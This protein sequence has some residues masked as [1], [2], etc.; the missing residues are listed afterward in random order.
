MWVLRILNAE[1]CIFS[2]RR[3]IT[4]CANV[5]SVIFSGVGYQDGWPVM[6]PHMMC[7]VIQD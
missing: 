2:Q 1:K 3:E 5:G 4:A 6:V 7:E